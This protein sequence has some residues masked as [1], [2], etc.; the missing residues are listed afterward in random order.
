MIYSSTEIEQHLQPLCRHVPW[1][2]ECMHPKGIYSQGCSSYP[3]GELTA[4][5]HT[6]ILIKGV[7]FVVKEKARE[8]KPGEYSRK[9][10]NRK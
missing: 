6:F 7:H 3:A 8:G 9:E 10:R 1:A 5:L 4:F 2:L